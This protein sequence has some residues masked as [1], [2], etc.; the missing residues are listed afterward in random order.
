MTILQ[1]AKLGFGEPLG[2][3]SALGRY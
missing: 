3:R 1:P 2:G